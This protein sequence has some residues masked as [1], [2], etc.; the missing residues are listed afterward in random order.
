[1]FSCCGAKNV[2][3]KNLDLARKASKSPEGK[4]KTA[5]QSAGKIMSAKN[6]T[7][8]TVDAPKASNDVKMLH[9]WA[10]GAVA[11]R[12]F[13]KF[14]QIKSI[15]SQKKP[16]YKDG[17][18]TK[19]NEVLLDDSDLASS[20]STTGGGKGLYWNTRTLDI[21]NG[22]TYTGQWTAVQKKKEQWTGL[23][24]IKFP[25]GSKYQGQTK[26]GLFHGKGRMTHSN[27]DIYQGEWKDGKASG[28][29]VF[30]DQQ[31]SMYEGQWKNDQYH[32]K[33]TEQWNYNQIVYTGDFVDGQKTGKGKFEFDGNVYEGDFVD[34]KFHGKGKY[35]FSESGKIYEGKFKENNMHGRGK[36]TWADGTYYDGEFKNG[37]TDG[38]G[39]RTYPNG[40]WVQG[41]FKDDKKHGP[42]I[43]YKYSEDKQM[44]VEYKN[45]VLVK[46]QKQAPAPYIDEDYQPRPRTTGKKSY[47]NSSSSPW[48]NKHANANATV[49]RRS[50][51]SNIPEFSPSRTEAGWAR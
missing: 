36:M 2:K 43:L 30:I 31:G 11:R 12:R 8:K 1:M 39:V 5:K 10:K 28:Q 29:G 17:K 37:K 15:A 20:L 34:G 51:K 49:P 21:K 13:K 33:G 46:T 47:G 25:D 27:G 50:T 6:S 48:R 7:G 42:A 38:Q 18:L 19:T 3:D 26:K 32:G 44:E 4:K 9:K 45:D 23:G 24:T 14:I 40:D 41:G 22:R 16:I 35:Y